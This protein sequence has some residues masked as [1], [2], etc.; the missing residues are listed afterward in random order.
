M[1]ANWNERPITALVD[2]PGSHAAWR[3]PGT[4]PGGGTCPA[5]RQLR[6]AAIEIARY[7]N[8]PS[9]FAGPTAVLGA[10]LTR[11][12]IG[13]CHRVKAMVLGS[14]LAD[15]RSIDDPN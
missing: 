15:R 6:C 7:R 13:A 3:K 10:D 12:T 4:L 8:A 9:R 1:I 2:A 14:D 11:Q 5:K